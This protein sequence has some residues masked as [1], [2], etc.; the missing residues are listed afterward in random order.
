LAQV[1]F[2]KVCWAVPSGSCVALMPDYPEPNVD[3]KKRKVPLNGR[4][5]APAA[6]KPPQKVEEL[7]AAT[8]GNQF[9]SINRPTAGVRTKFEYPG[10][11]EGPFQLY[12]LATPNG[13]KVGIL[14]EELGIPY[15]AHVVNIGKGDQFSSGFVAAN[16]NSKIPAA[17]DLEG[18][19][20]KPIS[21]FESGSIMLYLCKKHSRFLGKNAREEQE[22]M[23]WLFW[24]MAGQG[25]MTGNFGHFMVY[26]PDKEIGARNYGVAR[27]GMEVQRL[28]DVLDKHLE[29]RTYMVGDDITIADM[30]CMPWARQLFVGYNHKSGVGARQFLSGEKYKNIKA[31][32]ARLEERPTVQRGLSVCAGKPKPWLA[33]PSSKM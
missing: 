25:P 9:A 15:D 18:P 32:V 7:Y 1:G 30:A 23:N 5:V 13:H 26:A 22:V 8:S 31:W 33:Q 16:P 19:D 14:L 29:G 12:S 3:I 24:Q 4:E 2:K 6:W 28:A 27:Y 17:I 11:K 10:P 21:L 20:G